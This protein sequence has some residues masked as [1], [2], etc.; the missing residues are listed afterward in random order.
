MEPISKDFLEN[1][2]KQHLGVSNSERLEWSR[3]MSAEFKRTLLFALFLLKIETLTG[4]HAPAQAHKYE[5]IMRLAILIAH[6]NEL[7][8]F[9]N[10]RS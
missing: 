7:A 8:G 4:M 3:K 2:L 10:A 9:T 1:Y 6:M 5:A